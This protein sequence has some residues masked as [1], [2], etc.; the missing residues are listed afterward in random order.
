MTESKPDESRTVAVC[1]QNKEQNEQDTGFWKGHSTQYKFYSV[2]L[3]IIGSQ[4]EKG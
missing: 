2:T 3:P 1:I 4:G